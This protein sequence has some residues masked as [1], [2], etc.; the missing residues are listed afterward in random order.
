MFEIR[1]QSRKRNDFPRFASRR[2][3]VA[4]FGQDI[5]FSWQYQMITF[6]LPTIAGEDIEIARGAAGFNYAAALYAAQG[7]V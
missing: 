1:R 6:P 5:A 4:R 7:S 3:L 2:S